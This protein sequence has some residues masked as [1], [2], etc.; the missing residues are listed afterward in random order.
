M[1]AQVIISEG[2][3]GLMVIELVK[4]DRLLT[5]IRFMQE[6]WEDLVK[7]LSKKDIEPMDVV[8]AKFRRL[9]NSGV[10]CIPIP[11]LLES[12]RDAKADPKGMIERESLQT[13]MERIK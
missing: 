4:G 7:Q 13:M 10:N 6:E 8:I 2:T 9:H 5:Q 11:S 12:I 3:G 1:T